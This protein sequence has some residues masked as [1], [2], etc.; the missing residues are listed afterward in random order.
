MLENK[1][2]VELRAIYQG[3]G[4]KINWQDNK[5]KLIE[6]ITEKN[7]A[8]LTPPEPIY[9]PHDQ[10]LFTRPPAKAS[11]QHELLALL[12]DHITKGLDLQFPTPESW[13]M[14]YYKQMDSGTMRMPLRVVVGLANRMMEKKG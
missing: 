12:Q 14:R 9:T 10:K 8:T 3:M 2:L 11:S 1:S 6:L 13:S 7:A 5:A 4:G